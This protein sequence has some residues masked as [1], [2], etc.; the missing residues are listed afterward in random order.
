MTISVFD[1]GLKRVQ[2]EHGP[3]QFFFLAYHNKKLKKG[4]EVSKSIVTPKESAIGTGESFVYDMKLKDMEKL[5]RS[6]RCKNIV[7]RLFITLLCVILHTCDLVDLVF[8][9]II[10]KTLICRCLHNS[11][12]T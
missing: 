1:L 4:I 10:F 7:E 11:G 6:C 8:D 2:Y 9:G 12:A 3:F 5:R